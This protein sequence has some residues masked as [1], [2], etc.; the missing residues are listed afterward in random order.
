MNEIQSVEEDFSSKDL[1][2]AVD[3]ANR[4]YLVQVDDEFELQSWISS[5]RAALAKKPMPFPVL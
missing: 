4:R 5:I 3:T 1:C 2:F